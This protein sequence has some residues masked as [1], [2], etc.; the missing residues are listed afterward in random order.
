MKSSLE[1]KIQR[2]KE[3]VRGG[4]GDGA[5]QLANELIAAHE[6]EIRVWLLRG[7]LYELADNHVAAAADLTNA[8][9]LNSCEPHLY[10]TR[11]RY[12]FQ[13]GDN[14]GAVRDF[15][16]GLELCNRLNNDYY[17]AELHFWRAEALIRL[18][19]VQDA[20]QDLSQVGDDHRSW[21]YE[22][23]TKQDLL[24]DCNT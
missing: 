18:G 6:D 4:D 15:N 7:F 24:R 2:T 19:K 3:M 11:G 10:F 13:L 9:T 12:R 22:L 8:I 17:R 1:S 23:R 21:T 16:A 14:S 5:M 20:L